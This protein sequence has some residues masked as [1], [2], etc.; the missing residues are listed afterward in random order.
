MFVASLRAHVL[1]RLNLIPGG[2]K[3]TSRW[4]SLEKDPPLCRNLKTGKIPVLSDTMICPL[5]LTQPRA[6]SFNSHLSTVKARPTRSFW[7]PEWV[8]RMDGR[9]EVTR[10]LPFL[11]TGVRASSFQSDTFPTHPTHV[12]EKNHGLQRKRD[13]VWTLVLFIHVQG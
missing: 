13:L 7:S 9:A 3:A 12:E 11:W 1:L 6:S 4:V 10:T 8:P 5:C 2:R